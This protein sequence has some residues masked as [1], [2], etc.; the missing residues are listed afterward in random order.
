MRDEWTIEL[1][2]SLSGMTN[3]EA[4]ELL[5]AYRKHSESIEA[6]WCIRKHEGMAR[7]NEMLELALSCPFLAGGEAE[8]W[9]RLNPRPKKKTPPKAGLI[10][11]MRNT[12]NGFTKIG[13]STNPKHREKTLQSEEPEV[14]L[15]C[16]WPGTTD[17]ERSLHAKYAGKR[18]RGEWFNL[19]TDEVN[20]IGRAA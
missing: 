3:E 5:D 8:R 18:L 12:R 10:Y 17:D 7:D 15:L 14:E 4:F 13:F 2:R 20:E 19:S 6:A 1:V 9:A 16:S 11:L